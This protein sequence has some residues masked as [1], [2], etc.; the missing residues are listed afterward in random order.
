M[1]ISVYLYLSVR[2]VSGL[3]TLVRAIPTTH[4]HLSLS[5]VNRSEY[6][7]GEHTVAEVFL[8][9]TDRCGVGLTER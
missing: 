8:Y 4:T 3:T 2:G 5:S 7:I 9:G 1:F 6:I